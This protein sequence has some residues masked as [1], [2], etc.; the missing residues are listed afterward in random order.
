MQVPG[1]SGPQPSGPQ[2]LPEDLQPPDTQAPPTGPAGVA[3]GGPELRERAGKQSP[4]ALPACE[5][6]KVGVDLL[7]TGQAVI[8]AFGEA[9]LDAA[10]KTF[11]TR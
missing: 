9:R 5:L 1:P 3:P 4:P 8:Q 11:Q 6:V 2:M 7:S 10:G